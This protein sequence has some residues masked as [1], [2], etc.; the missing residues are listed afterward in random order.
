MK[1]KKYLKK[2]MIAIITLISIGSYG[3]VIQP[4]TIFIFINPSALISSTE[5]FCNSGRSS[6]DGSKDIFNLTLEKTNFLT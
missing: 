4:P 6:G 3:P 2:L 1:I 5:Y